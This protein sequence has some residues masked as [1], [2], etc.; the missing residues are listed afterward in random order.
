MET[1]LGAWAPPEGRMEVLLQ[2]VTMIYTGK[3][4]TRRRAW[5]GTCLTV[6]L[7]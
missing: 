4:R 5:A 3:P 2:G 7:I 1:A 6:Q